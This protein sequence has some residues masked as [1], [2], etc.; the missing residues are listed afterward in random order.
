M[1]V[2]RA[3]LSLVKNFEG[4]RSEAYADPGY[5]WKVATIGYGHTNNAGPPVVLKGM[6]I[7]EAEALRIL[8]NDLAGVEVQVREAVT[9]PLNDN[10]FGALVSFAFNCG[11]GALRKSTLLKKLN[12]GDYI[13]AADEFLKW[14]KSNKK[15]LAGLTKRREAERAL[16]LTPVTRVA[17][18]PA[19][20][21]E[22]APVAV[23]SAPAPSRWQAVKSFFGKVFRT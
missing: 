14:N 23:A 3:T 21:P 13:G 22:P 16:F 20:V 4:F 11:A 1:P 9:V 6:T 12:R 15:V 7:S 2:N 5:G 19:A 10:Q 18:A 8:E 17:A